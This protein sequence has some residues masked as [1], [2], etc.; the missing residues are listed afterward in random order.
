MLYYMK[1][2]SQYNYC[3]LG[4][5][6]NKTF[7][8]NFSELTIIDN[9]YDYDSL[10]SKLEFFPSKQ[11]VFNETFYYLNE[12]EIKKIIALLKQQNIKFINI[13]SNVEESVYSDYMIVYDKDDI[14][15]EGLTKKVLKEEKMLKRLGYGLPFSVDLSL[16]LK[17]YD[18]LDDV[19]YSIDE[20][21][22]KLWN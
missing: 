21:L 22:V 6:I 13:T 20:L 12:E 11:V 4:N 16:Q 8:K 3:V 15:I 17:F 9:L 7:L 2:D 5:C 14:V 10:K 19:C 18:V 1:F